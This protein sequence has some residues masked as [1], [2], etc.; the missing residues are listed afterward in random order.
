[1]LAIDTAREP[2]GRSAA[3]AASAPADSRW[4][5]AEG[6]QAGAALQRGTTHAHLLQA[7][8][9]RE[10]R[11]AR[12]AASGAHDDAI[13]AKVQ[14]RRALAEQPVDPADHRQETD[15]EPPESTPGRNGDG[16]A[17]HGARECRRQHVA[18]H[19]P[20]RRA[21]KRRRAPVEPGH[22]LG[23]QRGDVADAHEGEE[24]PR[25]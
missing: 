13:G 4:R 8:A 23:Q 16:G 24:R 7:P 14:A 1:M 18:A 9:P 2:P 12:R 6:R 25:R 11:H 3:W 15:R 10:Q 21:L 5:T 20:C 17:E 22:Q 19:A